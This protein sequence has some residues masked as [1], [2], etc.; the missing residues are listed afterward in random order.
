MK[1]WSTLDAVR[2]RTYHCWCLTLLQFRKCCWNVF[3]TCFHGI[4][5]VEAS[6]GDL[7]ILKS[8]FLCPCLSFLVD[9]REFVASL[10]SPFS[11][12][13]RRCVLRATIPLLLNAFSTK[14]WRKNVKSI[15]MK[16]A[17]RA[18][19]SVCRITTLVRYRTDSRHQDC[20]VRL[21]WNAIAHFTDGERRFL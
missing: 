5:V 12:L 10:P 1:A 16:P 3:N 11:S 21:P 14:I 2:L 8:D 15:S 13:P 17:W 7:R 9:E 4:F 20:L 19:K 6:S 18:A